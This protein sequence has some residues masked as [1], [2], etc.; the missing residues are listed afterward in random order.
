MGGHV[1]VVV[2]FSA[3]LISAR[4]S[5]SVDH[6]SEL[7]GVILGWPAVVGTEE[8]GRRGESVSR[9]KW[10]A[11]SPRE[12]TIKHRQFEVGRWW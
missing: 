8:H 9:A 6:A 1:M 10:H 4:E 3:S 5:L 11:R 12:L 2:R 7:A